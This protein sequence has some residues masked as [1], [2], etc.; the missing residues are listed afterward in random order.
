MARAQG[1][2][3]RLLGTTGSKRIQ[4]AHKSRD[5]RH[6]VSFE[7]LQV[8]TGSLEKVCSS[9]YECV[10]FWAAFALAFF[11][12]LRISELV[13]PSKKVEGGLLYRDVEHVQDTIRIWI[14]RSKTDQAGRGMTI[15]FVNCGLTFIL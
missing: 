14:R 5:G 2:H 9:F 6:P 7:M 8:L 13:S 11:A 4:E 15:G 12:A 1:L 10:L 3:K